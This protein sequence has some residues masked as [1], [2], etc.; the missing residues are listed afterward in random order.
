MSKELLDKYGEELVLD[1]SF[2]VDKPKKIISVGPALDLALNGG[3]PEGS[4]M[5]ISGQPKTLKTTITL[6]LCANAQKL[7]KM[8]FYNDVEGRLKK[9]N[10]LGTKD[11]DLKRFKVIGSTES[12]ILSA[13]EHLS[14]DEHLLKENPG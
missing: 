3:V 12:K 7:G 5:I 8:I 14:I 2:I 6:Q 4:W 11:L 9:L 10:L 13:E 1:A